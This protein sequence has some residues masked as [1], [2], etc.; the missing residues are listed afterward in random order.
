MHFALKSEINTVFISRDEHSQETR[1]TGDFTVCRILLMDLPGHLP[2]RRQPRRPMEQPR[3]HRRRR[4]IKRPS[5]RAKPREHVAQRK[6]RTC[7]TN[8]NRSTPLGNITQRSF[9]AADSAPRFTGAELTFPNSYDAPARPMQDSRHQ[10]S[11]RDGLRKL[12]QPKL[13]P[14]LRRGAEFAARVPVPEAAV[15]KDCDALLLEDEVGLAEE[16]RVSPATS[17]S[18][19]ARNRLISLSS[20]SR[21]RR[22]ECATSPR[23]VW[24]W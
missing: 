12:W 3:Q 7:L 1:S 5:S 8:R 6:T 19:C 15:N 20:V 24:P 23:C 13:G 22:L 21:S 18:C 2:R 4:L 11:A 16:S 14:A 10:P 9:D 17:D